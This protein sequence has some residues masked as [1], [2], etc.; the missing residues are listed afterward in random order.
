MK[1]IVSLCMVLIITFVFMPRSVFAEANENV[2]S[3]DT[4]IEEVSSGVYKIIPKKDIFL[5]DSSLN[6]VLYH[7]INGEYV[8]VAE[9]GNQSFYSGNDWHLFKD[10]TYYLETSGSDNFTCVESKDDFV[11]ISFDANC[12]AYDNKASRLEYHLKKGERLEIADHGQYGIVYPRRE[13]YTMSV[14]SWNTKEDA[15]GFNYNE[16]D[17]HFSKDLVFYAVWRKVVDITFDANGGVFKGDKVDPDTN[18]YVKSTHINDSFEESTAGDGVPVG[19]WGSSGDYYYYQKEG[20]LYTL[21]PSS[22]TLVLKEFNSKQDGS[23]DRYIVDNSGY[24][25]PH[26]AENTDLYAIWICKDDAHVFEECSDGKAATCTEK[27]KEADQKCKQCGYIKEGAE[28]PAAGHKWNTS[29]TV[30]IPAT[31][32]AEGQ[33]SIHC[34]VCNAEKE[35]SARTIPKN[36]KHVIKSISKAATCLESGIKKHYECT[37]CHKMFKDAAG[38]KELTKKEIKKLTIKK[39]KHNFKKKNK[40]DE[41]LKSSATCTKAAAYYYTC[42]MCG[43]KGKKTFKSGKALGH[44]FVAGN[45]TKATAKKYGKKASKCS[46][47]GKTSKGVKIPKTSQVFSLNKKSV[48]YT[49][50]GKEKDAISVRIRAG[51][52]PLDSKEFYVVYG[53]PVYGKKGKGSGTVTINFKPECKYY[54]GTLKLTYKITKV[55]KK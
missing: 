19:P 32:S 6:R 24:L 54:S 4:S 26:I 37:V 53:E 13:G 3:E 18:D 30:N 41:Y 10:N 47:C 33:E 12:G 43:V 42:S 8:L 46:R 52:F 21:M 25:D 20:T 39:K 22:D 7:E 51:K 36:D 23:G 44:D 28:I 1:K 45:I 49:G 38:K 40:S 14:D 50:S 31:H 34:S 35:G 11:V 48:A 5:Y 2:I 9:P 17:D 29:Y 27:G 15:T 16:F 55:P